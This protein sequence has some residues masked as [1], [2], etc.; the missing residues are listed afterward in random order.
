MCDL[1]GTDPL[2]DVVR[3]HALTL[4]GECVFYSLNSANPRHP[5]SQLT[6]T[7]STRTLARFLTQRSLRAMR[8][9]SAEQE[10]SDFNL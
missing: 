8:P 10:I 1:L 6:V 5:L 3:L 4:I 9:G 7:P 2:G